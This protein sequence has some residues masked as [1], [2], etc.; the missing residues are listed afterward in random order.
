MRYSWD[1]EAI[2]QTSNPLLVAEI[3]ID[4]E[5]APNTARDLAEQGWE[6]AEI[7]D[8]VFGEISS[9]FDATESKIQA[10]A[11]AVQTLL[12]TFEL[13]RGSYCRGCHRWEA[14]QRSSGQPR[15]PMAHWPGASCS[16]CVLSHLDTP[17]DVAEERRERASH[18]CPLAQHVLE[19][20]QEE[21][22]RADQR[23]QSRKRRE[24]LLQFLH[25]KRLE[26]EQIEAMPTSE[27]MMPEMRQR[28]HK[29]RAYVGALQRACWP[30]RG[31]VLSC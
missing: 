18:G 16:G 21:E 5:Q 22:R 30:T 13:R 17:Q 31:E 27:Q 1:Y 23:L 6:A 20:L 29:L 25:Q 10:R 24:A 7:A 8:A 11:E 3:L 12:T 2:A 19:H 26:L 15:R 9:A 28:S 14:G 4:L